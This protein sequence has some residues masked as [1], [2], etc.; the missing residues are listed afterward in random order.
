LTKCLQVAIAGHSFGGATTVGVLRHTDR[1]QSIGQGIIYDIWGAAIQSP[2]ERNRIQRLFL[3][4]NSEAFMYW[5]SNFKAVLALCEEAKANGALSWLMTVR[6]TVHLSP[7]DFLVLYPRIFSLFYKAT[8]NSHRAIL[9]HVNAFLEFLKLVMS[10]NIF[11]TVPRSNE[12]LLKVAP[13]DEL[14]DELKPIHEKWIAM[15]LRIPH[16]MT[17]RLKLRLILRHANRKHANTQSKLEECFQ[18]IQA[19]RR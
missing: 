10:Q 19:G 9:L 16:E 5:S 6:G 7:S 8:A 1:F 17:L 13:L 18:Q 3:C 15:R 4:I 14:P 12:K 11:T 2:E